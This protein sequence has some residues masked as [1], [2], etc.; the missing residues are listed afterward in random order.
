MVVDYCR[1]VKAEQD[2]QADTRPCR[3]TGRTPGEN[4]FLNVNTLLQLGGRYSTPAYP[5]GITTK[6]FNGCIRNL[7]HNGKVRLVPYLCDFHHMLHPV[8]RCN[9]VLKHFHYLMFIFVDHLNFEVDFVAVRKLHLY[10]IYSCISPSFMTC[11]T[12]RPQL[13]TLVLMAAHARMNT[14][15]KENMAAQVAVGSMAFVQAATGIE[16]R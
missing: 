12:K 4:T 2:V 6:G 1:A 14:A 15:C 5:Q 8:C 7:V 16:E 9:E 11:T 13:S 10:L 3:V